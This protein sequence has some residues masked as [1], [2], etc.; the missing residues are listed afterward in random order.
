MLIDGHMRADT[1]PTAVWPV[2]VLDVTEAEADKLLLT[3][4]PISAMAESNKEAL[5]KLLRDVDTGSEALQQM[6]AEL[7][8]DAGLYQ[9]SPE[10]TDEEVPERPAIPITKLGNVWLLGKHRLLCGNANDQ[11]DIQRLSP[12]KEWDV[13]VIDPPYEASDIV[14]LKWIMDPCI[15]FGQAKQLRLIPDSLWRFERVIV[16]RYKHRSA[17]TQV[18]HRHA[19]VAQCGSVKT[20][21]RDKKATLDSVVEQELNTEHDHQ[22][23]VSLLVE[24]LTHWTPPN[25]KAVVDPF[26]GSGSTLLAAEAMG[27]KC[28]AMELDPGWCDV[29]VQRWEAATQGKAV[30]ECEALENA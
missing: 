23:P 14:W 9:D 28:F 25:W 15:V 6:L 21:P 22:K 27:R 30:L 13:A 29:I 26:A 19:L 24:H 7:A 8:E 4:D 16:K 18:A 3:Y 20:L 2:L 10:A 17:T 5:D 12:G 1:D 11:R